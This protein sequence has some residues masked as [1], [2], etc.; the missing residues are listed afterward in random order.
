MD[1]DW[2]IVGFEEKPSR[3]KAIPGEPDSALVSMGNYLF[4][5]DTVIQALLEDARRESSDHD[6]GRDILPLLLNEE[7]TPTISKNRVP[8]TEK[9]EEPSYWRDLGTIEAYYEANMDLFRL[10]LRSICIT[11]AGRSAPRTLA[12]RRPSLSST[13]KIARHCLGLHRLPRYNY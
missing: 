3:P 11:A 2:R 10:I 7:S 13:G 9:G 8:S 5:A 1:P 6:F 4:N 12:I